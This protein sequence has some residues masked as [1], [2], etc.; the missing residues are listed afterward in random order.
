MNSHPQNFDKVT[1]WGWNKS[2][3]LEKISKINNRGVRRS[4][5]TLE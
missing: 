5:G 2:G 4:F 3:K 1:N